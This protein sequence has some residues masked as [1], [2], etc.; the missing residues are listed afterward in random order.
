VFAID[1][2]QTWLV[3]NHLNADEPEFDSVDRDG[4]IRQILGVGPQFEYEVISKEDWVGRRLVADRF[5]QGR[6]FIAGDAA[7]LWVP[8]AGY[9]MNAGIADATHLSWLLAAE[10]QG[11]GDARILDAYEAERQPITQQVSN[12]AMDHAAKMI[13]ARSAVPEDIEA[14]NEA[15]AAQRERIGAEAYALNVQQFCCAGLNFGYFYG[16]STL[17]VDDGEAPP[18]YSMGSFT[19]STVPGCRLPHVWLEDGRS[20]LDALGPGYT[21][22]QRD[23]S[24]PV[25][26][27]IAA[28]KARGMP[29]QV[30]SAGPRDGWPSAYRHALLLVRAD[31]HVVWRGDALPGDVQ[32]LIGRLC[33]VPVAA[34]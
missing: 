3:H 18:E 14:D 33:G 6:V 29:L 17:I 24:V 30:L 5:R 27:L 16:G 15:G 34:L 2:V 28:A 7:H 19:P 21:L 8:Y 20:V 25:G 4:S 13:R 22:L 1:G 23:P 9:G 32:A 11:W 12:F 26:A 10:V 31:S